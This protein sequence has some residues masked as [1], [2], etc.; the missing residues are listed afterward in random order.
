MEIVQSFDIETIGFRIGQHPLIAVGTSV[1][2]YHRKKDE[3]ELLATLEVHFPF[4]LDSCDPDTLKWWKSQETWGKIQED[5]ISLTEGAQKLVDFTKKWQEEA[6]LNRKCS[7]RL[8]TDN[9]WFDVHWIDWL[10]CTHTDDGHP[11]RQSYVPTYG[12]AGWIKIDAVIDI[13]QRRKGIE[14][15][16]L[17]LPKF[18][19][20]TAH[21]HTPV[22]DSMGIAEE[23]FHY[24]RETRKFR[25][26][27]LMDRLRSEG[28]IENRSKP[29]SPESQYAPQSATTPE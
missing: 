28:L 4:D 27:R 7:Y 22:S 18:E 8:L 26:L 16:G 5:Q 29:L 21:D 20:I 1:W 10:L 11:L 24:Q 6:I 14:A 17:S 25:K 19:K 2:S 3:S 15:L 12:K 13:R 23:Y 9:A